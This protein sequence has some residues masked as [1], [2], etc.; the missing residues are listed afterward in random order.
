MSSQTSKGKAA[1]K[2]CFTEYMPPS[3][4]REI[5]LHPLQ[6][7]HLSFRNYH[8][9]TTNHVFVTNIITVVV[10]FCVGQK[11]VGGN[12]YSRDYY[13]KVFHCI[14]VFVIANQTFWVL[15]FKGSLH[16]RLGLGKQN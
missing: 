8:N 10:H 13:K 14:F 12:I 15:F 4:V 2:S 7:T 11:Q 1:L 9:E 5:A 6:S 16:F 3:F